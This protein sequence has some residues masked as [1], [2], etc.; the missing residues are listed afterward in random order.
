MNSHRRS[1][2][3]CT[4]TIFDNNVSDSSLVLFFS[5]L[6]TGLVIGGAAAALSILFFESEEMRNI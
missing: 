6:S 4:L 1:P 3:D 5:L 2:S